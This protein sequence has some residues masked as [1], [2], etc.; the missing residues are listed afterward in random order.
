MAPHYAIRN[1]RSA[2][3][4]AG[5]LKYAH[6]Q[7]K[8]QDLRQENQNC[9]NSFPDPLNQKRFEPAMAKQKADLIACIIQQRLKC[10]AD[11]QAHGK[12]NLKDA[13][14][15]DQKQQRPC[16]APQQNGIELACPLG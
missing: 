13:E 3:Q 5:I 8:Q 2:G 6:K 16:H 9:G 15:D 14:N 4:I 12:H 7:K 10:I 11:W 1:Q